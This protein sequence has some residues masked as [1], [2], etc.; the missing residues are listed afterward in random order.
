MMLLSLLRLLR[1][2]LRLRRGRGRFLRVFIPTS[3]IL[4]LNTFLNFFF[5]VFCMIMYNM[6]LLYQCI[7]LVMMMDLLFY[8]NLPIY[9]SLCINKYVRIFPN[10][11]ILLV[12]LHIIFGWWGFLLFILWSF[13]VAICMMYDNLRLLFWRFSF[14]V[15]VHIFG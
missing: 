2:K 11:I 13:V 10:L 15:K 9:L 6:R 5:F 3:S 12:F 4:G 1:W 8:M 14:L 7:I